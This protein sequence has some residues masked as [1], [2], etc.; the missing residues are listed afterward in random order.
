MFWMKIEIRKYVYYMTPKLR[1]LHVVLVLNTTTQTYKKIYSYF[2]VSLHMI[3]KITKILRSE[4]SMLESKFTEA[5]Y[6]IM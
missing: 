3:V 6:L 4:K 2:F 1:R 5:K